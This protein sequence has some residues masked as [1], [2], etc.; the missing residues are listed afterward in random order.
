MFVDSLS[1]GRDDHH[2][3]H[4]DDRRRARR[5]AACAGARPRRRR[6]RVPVTRPMV[7][8][9][10]GGGRTGAGRVRGRGDHR[11]RPAR[12]VAGPRAAPGRAAARRP[13][14]DPRADPAQPA[15]LRQRPRLRPR[16]RRAR[17]AGHRLGERRGLGGAHRRAGLHRRRRSRTCAASSSPTCTSTTSAWPRASGRRA[18][19]GSRCTRP[20]P[21]LVAGLTAAGRGRDG[22][23]R[24]RVPGRRWA[25]T[26][27]RPS[28]TSGPRRAPGAFTRMAVPDR[29][30]EDGDL[31]DFPGW[32]MRAVHTPG[33]TPGPPV[34]RRGGHPA[35][36]L[37]RPRPPPDQPEH[38][39]QPRRARR[40]AAR[41]PR[42]AGRRPRP[43][44]GRGAAGARVALPRAGRPGGR[45]DRPPRAPADRAA[46]RDPRA[47]AD[48]RRGSSPRT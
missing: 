32:R 20:T 6:E 45:A 46:G 11:H 27:R 36:L 2:H 33:H 9:P 16:R 17:P 31:A 12:G 26:A 29:L 25:P 19:P 23:L 47:P 35:V 39:H 8:A 30:L 21:T 42:L 10:A 44:P 48:R 18:A 7:A 5:A 24:G 38:L 1:A 43:R 34:L 13:L 40:S 4:H 28:A 41:L 3:G 14:V 22:R 15:A 37:R